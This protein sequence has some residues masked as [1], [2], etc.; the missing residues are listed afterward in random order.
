MINEFEDVWK[1][2]QG[3]LFLKEENSSL[4]WKKNLAEYFYRR[5]TESNQ[6]L[7]RQKDTLEVFNMM[8]EVVIAAFEVTSSFNLEEMF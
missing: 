8:T 4:E 3:A 7:L 6:K 2:Q 5:G 1:Y